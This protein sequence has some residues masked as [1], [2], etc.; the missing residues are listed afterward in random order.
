VVT[1]T[2]G[3]DD[4]TVRQA[5]RQAIRRRSERLIEGDV[6]VG[7]MAA[8]VLLVPGST[9]RQGAAAIERQMRRVLARV[10]DDVDRRR[11]PL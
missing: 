2:A 9:S 5:V 11:W 7:T 1:A 8:D 6:H 10:R 3:A 4:E